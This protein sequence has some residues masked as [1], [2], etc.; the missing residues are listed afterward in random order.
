MSYIIKI[1]N[2]YKVIQDFEDDILDLSSTRDVFEVDELIAYPVQLLCNKG[3]ITEMSCAGHAFGTL[4]YESVEKDEKNNDNTL[5]QELSYDHGIEFRC[6]EGIPEP[7]T[8]IKFAKKIIF[9]DLSCGWVQEGHF[10]KYGLAMEKDPSTYYYKLTSG[11]LCLT[12]WIEKL[13]GI[14]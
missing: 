10:L 13:P 8:F 14:K 4:H 2:K 12:K 9:K 3:Y 1:D 6:Y 7:Y 5:L 11:M